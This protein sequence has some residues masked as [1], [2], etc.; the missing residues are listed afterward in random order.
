M[1]RQHST[2]SFADVA[3]EL[4]GLAA[5]G[6]ILTTVLFPFALPLLLLVLVTPVVLIVRLARRARPSMRLHGHRARAHGE[7]GPA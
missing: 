4:M 7:P 1:N 5:G 6:G 3:G 2:P